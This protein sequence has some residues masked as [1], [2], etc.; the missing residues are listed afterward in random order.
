MQLLFTNQDSFLRWTSDRNS[1]SS[2]IQQATLISMLSKCSRW[3]R[4]LIIRKMAI[5]DLAPVRSCFSQRTN[6]RVNLRTTQRLQW[7]EVL[8]D[9]LSRRQ[10]CKHNLSETITHSY[11]SRSL[12]RTRSGTKRDHQNGILVKFKRSLCYLRIILEEE[13]D[14]IQASRT[15]MKRCPTIRSE[16]FRLCR[17]EEWSKLT[18]WMC[19]NN[20]KIIEGPP[21]NSSIE[22]GE[23]RTMIRIDLNR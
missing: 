12:K 22:M 3:R 19:L 5:R 4:T 21:I 1:S 2:F 16:A 15:T 11:R 23:N 8:Q 6:S 18:K 7:K 14:Q 13:S 20:L 9:R 10:E 17:Q